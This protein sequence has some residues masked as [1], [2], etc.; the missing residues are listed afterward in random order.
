M[1]PCYAKTN[2]PQLDAETVLHNNFYGF[3]PLYSRTKDGCLWVC[4]LEKAYAKLNRSYQALTG[5]TLSESLRDLTGAPCL[6]FNFQRM[7][8]EKR[9]EVWQKL[10][11]AKEAKYLYGCSSKHVTVEEQLQG[12]RLENFGIVSAH[13]YGLL[14]LKEVKGHKLLLLRNPWG[15]FSWKGRWSHG[16][17]EWT[18]Q[19]M[20]AVG[21]KEEPGTFWMCFEDFVEF[22]DEVTV[23]KI[24]MMTQEDLREC[25]LNGKYSHDS[26]YG[27]QLEL[28][29]SEQHTKLLA[30]LQKRD[31]RFSCGADI[32]NRHG[33][34]IVIGNDIDNTLVWVAGTGDNSKREVEL[35]VVLEPLL[36]CQHYYLLVSA[37]IG[38]VKFESVDYSLVFLV[39]GGFSY[40]VLPTDVPRLVRTVNAHILANL[41]IERVV[42]SSLHTLMHLAFQKENRV[43]FEQVDGLSDLLLVLQRYEAK[44]DV[45]KTVVSL[46]WNLSCD[47]GVRHALNSLHA[48]S[49]ITSV[50]QRHDGNVEVAETCDIAIRNLQLPPPT[51]AMDPLIEK[52][53]LANACTFSVTGDKVQTSTLPPKFHPL[54]DQ[55]Y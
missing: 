15:E 55:P 25:K 3:G 4:Y 26:I 2:I 21:Y 13:A 32:D 12:V 18:T 36:P 44:K 20:E 11:E 51:I 8:P 17:S 23:C 45:V 22:F 16:S 24:G 28:R 52:C 9:Q 35:E 40:E 30:I 41:E 43:I 47:P 5:G 1:L 27:P 7:M 37:E 53:I 31:L 14:D 29:V 46:L 6:T 10:L 19:L 33:I 39:S 48:A 34:F 42:H 54:I 50:R 49:T 38:N